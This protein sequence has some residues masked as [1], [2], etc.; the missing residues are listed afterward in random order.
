MAIQQMVAMVEG[1]EDHTMEE[2]LVVQEEAQLVVVATVG[3][4]EEQE[5]AWRRRRARTAADQEAP[6]DRSRA[7]KEGGLAEGPPA[8]WL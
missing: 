5:L 6:T 8:G 1:Q 4:E 7:E 3:P 2:D